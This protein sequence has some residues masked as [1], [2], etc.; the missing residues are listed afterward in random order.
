MWLFS[1]KVVSTKLLS[2]LNQNLLDEYIWNDFI[3]TFYRYS[4]FSVESMNSLII[5]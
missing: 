1:D 3:I 4:A 5:Y 2:I